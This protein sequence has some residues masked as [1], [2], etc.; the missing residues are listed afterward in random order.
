VIAVASN[1][2]K[3]FAGAVGE[4]GWL[5]D[6]RFASLRD[7]QANQNALDALIEKKMRQ[8]SAAEW[9]TILIAAGVPCGRVNTIGQSIDQPQAVAR[10]M[11][12]TF[13]DDG[14]REVGVAGSPIKF[15]GEEERPQRPPVPRGANTVES[16]RK[17]GYGSA[18]I[19]SLRAKGIIAGD[20]R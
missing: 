10:G 18:E 11:H 12:V 19:E 5:D 8:R 4:P 6:A 9:E 20:S 7:R 17:A 15:L 14:G 16:L 2:W 3:A 1:F 13:V